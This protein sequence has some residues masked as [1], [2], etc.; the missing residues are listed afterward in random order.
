VIALGDAADFVGDAGP[1]VAAILAHMHGA[2]GWLRDLPFPNAMHLR[3][4]FQWQSPLPWHLGPTRQ[5]QNPP[6]QKSSAIPA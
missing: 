2:L 1:S 4:P 3:H 6:L 5:S